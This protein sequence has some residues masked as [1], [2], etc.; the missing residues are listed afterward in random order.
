MLQHIITCLEGLYQI[1]LLLKGRRG[2]NA[3]TF[4]FVHVKI[5][6]RVINVIHTA[7]HTEKTILPVILERIYVRNVPVLAGFTSQEMEASCMS[8]N[9]FIWIWSLGQ[10][11]L[12]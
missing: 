3:K 12:I 8:E 4:D 7:L 9:I 2:S 1:G 5:S 6:T 11:P 10:Q